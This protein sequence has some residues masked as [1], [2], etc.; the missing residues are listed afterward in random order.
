MRV[1]TLLTLIAV[2]CL[3]VGC[4]T[5][6]KP[7]EGLGA[8]IG[9]SDGNPPH[10]RAFPDSWGGRVDFS[11]E[12]GFEDTVDDKYKKEADR[13]DDKVTTWSNRVHLRF[14]GPL[15]WEGSW[16]V[17]RLN[18]EYVDYDWDDTN[19]YGDAQFTSLDL[20]Y[21]Q[22]LAQDWAAGIITRVSSS[23]ENGAE[24]DDGIGFLIAAGAVHMFSDT[25]FIGG[26]VLLSRSFDDHWFAWP[27]I[28]GK[29]IF[30]DDWELKLIG[31]RGEVRWE[32][33]EKMTWLAGVEIN[34]SRFLLDVP[35]QVALSDY[36][37]PIYLGLEYGVAERFQINAKLGY[38]V[39][40]EITYDDHGHNRKKYESDGAA[41]LTGGF[42]WYF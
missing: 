30:A 24:F 18:Y 38:D 16:L 14:D 8:L 1:G 6:S 10:T 5:T 3:F 33:D 17:T 39:Y 15:G 31:P 34:A 11:S 21:F 26:G 13:V 20:W 4:S 9:S 22:G 12:Y 35:G 27:A 23:V 42:T 36:R 29:W 37:V 28:Q 2:A 40:R 25:L 7:D 32:Q 19:F 41:S